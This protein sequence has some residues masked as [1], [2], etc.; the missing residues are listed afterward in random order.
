MVRRPGERERERE[1]KSTDCCRRKMITIISFKTIKLRIDAVDRT[2][3]SSKAKIGKVWLL[4]T[5][6]ENGFN[7]KANNN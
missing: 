2:N 7:G 6:Y 5:I 4:A 3:L 1:R